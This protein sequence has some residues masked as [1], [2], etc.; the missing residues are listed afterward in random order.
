M[1]TMPYQIAA[2]GLLLVGEAA[3][4]EDEE[5]GGGEVEGRDETEAHGALLSY[6]WNMASIRRVTRNPPKMFTEAISVASAASSATEDAARA[7]LQE[8]RR[9]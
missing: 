8:R 3:E 9:G 2:L 5:D 7:D 1:P 4:R 6:F